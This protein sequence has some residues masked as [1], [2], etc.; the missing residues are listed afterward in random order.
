M[1]SDTTQLTIGSDVWCNDR[2]E[3]KLQRVVVEPIDRVLT[4]LVVLPDHG[5]ETERL[6]PIDLVD[7]TASEA[8]GVI[9]LSCTDTEFDTLEDAQETQFLPGAAEDWGYAQEQMLSWPYYGIRMGA[10]MGIAAAGSGIGRD[11]GLFAGPQ[12]ITR[13][14]VPVGEVQV[15][16][17]QHV[18]AEDGD[19]GRVQDEGHLWGHKRVAIPIGSV[20]DVD[21]G[22]RLNLSKDEVRDLPPV[23][24]DEQR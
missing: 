13:D 15:R 14:R 20:S 24:L 8:A 17:G 18:H 21:D 5:R 3:G 2:F 4:H 10:G 16:R 11:E 23:D 19:I 22:V 1:T 6:V 7:A 12:E 9:R